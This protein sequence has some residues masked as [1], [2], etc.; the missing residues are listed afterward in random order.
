MPDA[1]IGEVFNYFSSNR[2]NS[3][4][5]AQ[6]SKDWK[7]LSEQDKDDLRKGIGDGSLDY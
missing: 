5:M 6:F 3:Y 1:N 4:T 7:A 2:T